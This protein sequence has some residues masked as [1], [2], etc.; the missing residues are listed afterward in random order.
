MDIRTIPVPLD[1]SASSAAAFDA[2]L[3]LAHRFG[4][5]LQLLHAIQLHTAVYPY[6]LI[7][8][9]DMEQKILDVARSRLEAFTQK[10]AGRGVESE[11]TVSSGVAVDAILS[12]AKS[13]PA[14]VIVMGTRGLGGLKH[15][16]LGS[17]AERTVRLAPCPVLTVKE[18]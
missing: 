7:I 18:G 5:K 4:A 14:D 8:A 3:E 13:L 15:V 1:F 17:V 12:L 2:A 6:G 16:V 9:E 10:A 11:A